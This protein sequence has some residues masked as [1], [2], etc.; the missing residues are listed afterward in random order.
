M[1]DTPKMISYNDLK[2]VIMNKRTAIN[3]R[4][5]PMKRGTQTIMTGEFE[6]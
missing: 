2:E 5:K 3:D 6:L 4:F 1:K